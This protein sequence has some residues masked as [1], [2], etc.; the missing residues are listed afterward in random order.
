MANGSTTSITTTYGGEFAGKYVS[1][2]LLRFNL[3]QG[4]ITIRITQKHSCEKSSFTSIVKNGMGF[5][6]S[7]RR[8]NIN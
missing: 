2:A 1:A 5:F 4:N 7:S 8:F 6:R 3:S